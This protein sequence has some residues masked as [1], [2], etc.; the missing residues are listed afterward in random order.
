MRFGYWWE[1]THHIISL[2]LWCSASVYLGIMAFIGSCAHS[3]AFV[4]C[5]TFGKSNF[6]IERQRWR[7]WQRRR[8]CVRANHFRNTHKLSVNIYV[9]QIIIFVKLYTPPAHWMLS[10]LFE[11]N[12]WACASKC[13]A[14]RIYGWKSTRLNYVFVF[15]SPNK[16]VKQLQTCVV[17]FSVSTT[18]SLACTLVYAQIIP[19]FATI[20]ISHLTIRPIFVGAANAK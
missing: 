4:S 10:L 11:Y 8:A 2:L 20:C 6:G 12:F 5:A 3:I 14:K 13:L 16:S 7:Q 19:R 9:E 17:Q 15:R 1:R 18:G